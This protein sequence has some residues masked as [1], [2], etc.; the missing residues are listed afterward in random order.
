MKR[1]QIL[2]ILYEMAIVIGGEIRLRPLLTKTLQ[3][4]L[5]HTS[6]PCGMIFLDIAA[7]PDGAGTDA[8]AQLRLEISIGD[9]DLARRH[10]AL[11]TLPDALKHGGMEMAPVGELLAGIPCRQGHYRVFFRLPVGA[12][13]VILLL[14]PH[15]PDTDLPLTQV[16]Q[17]VMSNFA[18]AIQLCRGYEAFTEGIISDQRLARAEL[19]DISYRQRLI[20][21]SVGEGICGLD[22]DGNATF[23]NPAA[24]KIL[25]F[26]PEELEGSPMHAI[27]H[28]HQ[29]EEAGDCP[30]L[31]TMREGSRQRIATDLFRRRDGSGFPV[32][33]VSTPLMENGRIVGTVLVFRDITERVRAEER[34]RKL[35]EELEERVRERTV[36]LESKNQ[37]LERLN[38]VFVGRELRMV[39]LKER[40][41]TLEQKL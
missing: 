34:I 18:K 1:E 13:G 9:L 11:F 12:F 3:R 38:K 29:G 31:R 25:G 21:E 33:Y 15:E 40:I 5:F 24:A 35:N 6:F 2:A 10:G 32:E 39:E 20:L 7:D 27:L 16:F 36:E 23:V 28:L 17:P 19:N 22:L 26:L 14:S 37:E 41:R 4:L 8:P 30:I